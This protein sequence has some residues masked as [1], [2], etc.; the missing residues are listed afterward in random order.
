MEYLR[1]NYTSEL[2]LKCWI[3]KHNRI[4]LS[5]SNKVLQNPK[6]ESFFKITSD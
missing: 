2:P 6:T 3:D 4:V 5:E 1:D